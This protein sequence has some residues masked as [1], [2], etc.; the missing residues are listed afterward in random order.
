M[1]LF[2]TLAYTFYSRGIQS[3]FYSKH[4]K[5]GLIS[6]SPSV[7]M[8]SSITMDSRLPWFQREIL[9]AQ[10]TDTFLGFSNKHLAST[11][12]GSE[13]ALPALSFMSSGCFARILKTAT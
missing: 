9:L 2:L 13:F 3:A 6:V 5:R 11:S 7:G 8:K 4:E 1:K 10:E 12:A